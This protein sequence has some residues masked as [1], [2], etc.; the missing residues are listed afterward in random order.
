M[1][2][3]VLILLCVALSGFGC[4]KM[5]N[6]KDITGAVL[7]M[8][9]AALD[10]WG[11]GDPSGFLEISDGDVSYFDNMQEMRLDGLEALTKYYESIRGQVH[12]DRF[13]LI[14]PKVQPCGDDAAVL[15][16]NFV[17]TN[18]EKTSR[19]NCTEVYKRTDKG[20]RIIH[21]HWSMT[22]PSVK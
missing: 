22:R 4:G 3:G 2:T 15:T 6:E 11:K 1:R 16:Y 13:E 18:G 12:L 9:K 19:W 8:E 5:H 10:R 17:G 20:W 7:S 21:T 14:H